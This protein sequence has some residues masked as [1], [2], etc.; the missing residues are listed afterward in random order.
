M[1]LSAFGSLRRA[2]SAG[3]IVQFSPQE[4]KEIDGIFDV[5]ECE[6]K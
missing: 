5:I 6:I 1:S 4:N 3:L 2:L